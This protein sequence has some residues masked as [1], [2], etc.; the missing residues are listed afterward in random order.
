M[1]MSSIDSNTII[2]IGRG[3]TKL[4]SLS[5]II[6]IILKLTGMITWSWFWVLFPLWILPCLMIS[7]IILYTF[8][9]ISIVIM[10]ILKSERQK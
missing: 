8:G 7:I 5:G 1:T 4:L 9:I 3:G 6:F 10:A 2:K